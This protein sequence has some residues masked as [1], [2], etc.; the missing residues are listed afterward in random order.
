M[1]VGPT[2]P[3]NST[4]RRFA[5]S[6]FFMCCSVASTASHPKWQNSKSVQPQCFFC[7]RLHLLFV[8]CWWL[9]LH[10]MQ[11]ILWRCSSYELFTPRDLVVLTTDIVNHL[12]AGWRGEGQT[13]LF[14][15][16]DFCWKIGINWYAFV[17]SV[18]IFFCL[19][20][21]RKTDS[22][23]FSDVMLLSRIC[24]EDT[25]DNFNFV[26]FTDLSSVLI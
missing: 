14:D 4:Q 10:W 12:A 5:D 15:W 22:D 3:H 23:S 1:R 25:H 20:T 6:H 26:G 9:L 24:M 16:E 8:R 21:D 2:A 7:F 18:Q 19:G 11:F 13:G 17:D